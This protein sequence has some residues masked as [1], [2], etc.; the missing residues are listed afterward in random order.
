MKQLENLAITRYNIIEDGYMKD[1]Y[2]RMQP[3]L[4]RRREKARAELQ[5]EERF[6][7]RM[8]ERLNADK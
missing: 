5:L 8:E 4:E 6:R 1:L 2:E 3:D 7:K